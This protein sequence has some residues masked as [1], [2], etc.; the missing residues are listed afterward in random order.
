[1]KN[2]QKSKPVELFKKFF[3]ISI[4]EYI[5]EA[6]KG[7]EFDLQLD[8]LNT[9]IG[10]IILSSINKKKSQRDFWSTDPYLS[11]EVV[12]SAMQ[13]NKFEGIKSKLKWRIR[14]LLKLSQINIRQFGLWKTALSV[15]EMMDKL[16]ARTSLKQFI[17]GKP[18]R[19]GLKFRGLCT[20]G[21]YVLNLDLYCG[22]NSAITD[23]LAKCT[24]GSQVVMNLL[25]P[26]LETTAPGKIPRIHLYC[27]NYFTNFDLLVHLKKLGLRCIRTIREK[28]VKTKFYK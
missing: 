4:K 14:K 15:D 23:E 1:M 16:Y 11:L 5:I 26:F 6:C 3:T 12:R 20:A 2:I 27:D 28:R 9:F 8:D 13:Q 19:F 18:I 22:E 17:R 24:L 7:N 21:E 25:E 10:I